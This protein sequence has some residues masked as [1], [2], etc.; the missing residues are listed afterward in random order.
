MVFFRRGNGITI[1][2]VILLPTRKNFGNPI[3][4]CNKQES[5][6]QNADLEKW[7]AVLTE[8]NGVS[9]WPKGRF[10]KLSRRFVRSLSGMAFLPVRLAFGK[11]TSTPRKSCMVC[12]V[13]WQR[14]SF[15]FLPRG[16]P[17]VGW[18]CLWFW[19]M[20]S[21]R[22]RLFLP[23]GLLFRLLVSVLRVHQQDRVSLLPRLT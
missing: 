8:Q 7:N 15:R 6:N 19:D 10:E 22:S 17:R 21:S 16:F 18:L 2:L 12:P 9:F 20:Q 13:L 23:G 3:L 4:L 5:K 14:F 11:S 1:R